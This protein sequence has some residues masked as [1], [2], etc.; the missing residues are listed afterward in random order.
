MKYPDPVTPEMLPKFNHI[1]TST[2]HKDIAETEAEIAQYEKLQEANQIEADNHPNPHMRDLAQF[3][4]DARPYQQAERR[5][6][7]A[8]LN[9]IL[10]AREK[11]GL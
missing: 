6:F 10:A 7:V 8:F 3:K 9:R 11:A 5:D 2:I 4:A 1:P